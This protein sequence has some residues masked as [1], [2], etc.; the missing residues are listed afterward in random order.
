M[1]HLQLLIITLL[2]HNNADC[3]NYPTIETKEDYVQFFSDCQG[4]RKLGFEND[5]P[6]IFNAS[7]LNE[8]QFNKLFRNVEK[9]RMSLFIQNTNFRKPRFRKLRKVYVKKGTP[10]FRIENNPNLE[11]LKA[12]RNRVEAKPKDAHIKLYYYA[13]GRGADRHARDA[14]PF[15]H[16]KNLCNKDETCHYAKDTEC[17]RIE[18]PIK[19]VDEFFHKCAG[20]PVIK[21][22]PGVT[23]ELDIAKLSSRQLKLLFEN[24]THVFMC[25]SATNTF[26]RKIRFPQL[27]HIESCEGGDHALYLE[28]NPFLEKVLLP[29]RFTSDASFRIRGNQVLAPTNIVSLIELCI[30]CDI[31]YPGEQPVA[32]PVDYREVCEHYPVPESKKD[33]QHLVEMCSGVKKL[34]FDTPQGKMFYFEAGKLSQSEFEQLFKRVEEINFAINVVGTDYNRLYIPNLKRIHSGVAGATVLKVE[35]NRN[36]EH[37]IVH[38]DVDAAS[39][40]KSKARLADNQRLTDKFL[41]RWRLRICGNLAC[42]MKEFVECSNLDEKMTTKQ[43]AES[44]SG[45][46]ILKAGDGGELR[47]NLNDLTQDEIYDLFENVEEMH[48]CIKAQNTTHEELHFP[49]LR[50]LVTCKKGDP[51]LVIENNKNLRTL[52]FDS[53]FK[54]EGSAIVKNNPGLSS[55]DVK[56]LSKVCKDHCDLRNNCILAYAQELSPEFEITV[57]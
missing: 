22:I 51:A 15:A 19:D 49:S 1:M 13:N 14:D 28:N 20:A 54:I 4:A 39:I 24:A 46:K 2:I 23:L 42:D 21:A 53:K 5:N 17:S 12:P 32:S 56:R 3:W 35:N 52:R 27:V 34:E 30:E 48:A 26:H 36:M 50:K 10:S 33:Y 7:M 11:V 44:C 6:W 40:G 9:M 57:V 37:I 16:I 43:V 31:Q 41:Q 47:L 55:F 29:C 38:F 18:D 45:K 25:I 8:N